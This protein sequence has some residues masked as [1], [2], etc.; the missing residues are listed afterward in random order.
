[1]HSI[2]AGLSKKSHSLRHKRKGRCDYTY[3]TTLDV[4]IGEESQMKRCK[5]CIESTEIF[6]KFSAI[7]TESP[8]LPTC[9]VGI[10]FAQI[11]LLLAVI[12]GTMSLF[13]RASSSCLGR[14]Q[15][16]VY[17][18]L[19]NAQIRGRLGQKT[20]NWTNILIKI[21]KSNLIRGFLVDPIGVDPSSRP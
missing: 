18:P 8:T 6:W 13:L 19:V 1:M 10:L 3:K 11:V 7:H 4:G 17:W 14:W 21:Q 5:V 20:Q 16:L 2:F 9:R 12:G 15:L